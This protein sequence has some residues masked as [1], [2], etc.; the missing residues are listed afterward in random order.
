VS[1]LWNGLLRMT[2]S[3]E[4]THRITLGGDRSAYACMYG[5][6]GLGTLYICSAG[7]Y[8]NEKARITRAGRI[9]TIVTGFT[10]AGLD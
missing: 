5:G 4:V 2:Y 9:E 1:V 10:G 8:D 6:P 3:G 7:P